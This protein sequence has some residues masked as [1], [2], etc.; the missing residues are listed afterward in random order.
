MQQ[1][2]ESRASSSQQYWSLGH[3]ITGSN[4]LLYSVVEHY[5]SFSLAICAGKSIWKLNIL[6]TILTELNCSLYEELMLCLTKLTRN[7]NL[8]NLIRAAS[9]NIL[10]RS[11]HRR[12]RPATK[13]I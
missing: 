3:T 5:I 4:E 12:V 8:T 10:K 6:L 11:R 2:P 1:D 13:A 7:R 9:P